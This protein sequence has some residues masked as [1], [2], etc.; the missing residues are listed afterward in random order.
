MTPRGAKGATHGGR[1]FAIIGKRQIF[2]PSVPR[3][4]LVVKTILAL[5]LRL[6]VESCFLR[7]AFASSKQNEA[8]PPRDSQNL[9]IVSSDDSPRTGS[10]N[11]DCPGS[12]EKPRTRL[13]QLA[14]PGQ[15][16]GTRK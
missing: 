13:F 2:S 5:R 16:E 6:L 11:N 9:P 1:C 7:V 12:R 15:T 3:A 8:C 4:S 10:P 14:K